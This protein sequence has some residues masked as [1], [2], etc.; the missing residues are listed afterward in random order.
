MIRTRF[1]CGLTYYRTIS[2]FVKR[3]HGQIILPDDLTPGLAV[4]EQLH[5]LLLLLLAV[6]PPCS[7]FSHG[8]FLPLEVYHDLFFSV[9]FSVAY[10]TWIKKNSALSINA[11][12][13]ASIGYKSS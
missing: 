9:Q 12:F 11:G 10:P 2:R 5:L 3:G 7:S 4:V 8:S 1:S 13:C 6:R